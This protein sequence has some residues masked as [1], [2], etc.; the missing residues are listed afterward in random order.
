MAAAPT[1]WT[2]E[3]LDD[4]ADRLTR[5]E[6]NVDGR[7]D[8]LEA[9][10]DRFERSVDQRFDKVDARFDKWDRQFEKLN[11]KMDRLS[12]HVNGG[13]VTIVAAVIIKVFLG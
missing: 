4:D 3:R 9:R 13:L 11:S 1:R 2:D 8:R 5:F 12:H 10:F 6:A 7:F